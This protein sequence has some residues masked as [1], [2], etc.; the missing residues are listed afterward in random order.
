MAVDHGA[1]VNLSKDSRVQGAV[2]RR[3]YPGYEEFRTS[4]AEYDPK[5]RFDSMLR[6]RIDV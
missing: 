6:R 1:L 2:V 5:R 3:L 4:L